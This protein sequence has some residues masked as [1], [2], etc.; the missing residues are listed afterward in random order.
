MDHLLLASL[1]SPRCGGGT[2]IPAFAGMTGAD[3]GY[4]KAEEHT[5]L[6]LSISLGTHS[7]RLVL[8]AYCIILISSSSMTCV[9]R[10]GALQTGLGADLL[11]HDVLDG[12]ANPA[13]DLAVGRQAGP[14]PAV[15][16]QV[17]EAAELRIILER[18]AE[19]RMVEA[20]LADG[21]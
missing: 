5:P 17:N 13:G 19:L 11:G 8:G 10:W 16:S 12:L 3:P 9:S 1:W 15:R 2:W 21:E 14:P 18:L 4:S 7:E 6:G 20:L